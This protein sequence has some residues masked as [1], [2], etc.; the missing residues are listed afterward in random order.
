M[1]INIV[2][3]DEKLIYENWPKAGAYPHFSRVEHAIVKAHCSAL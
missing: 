1:N 3:V 2:N